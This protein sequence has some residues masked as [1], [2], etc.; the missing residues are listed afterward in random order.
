MCFGVYS[1]HA[2]VNRERYDL[3]GGLWDIK[4]V[5]P[6][7]LNGIALLQGVKKSFVVDMSTVPPC[8]Y[9]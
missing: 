6:A 7:S 5:Q 9:K 3:K 1:E 2:G 8:G 4:T